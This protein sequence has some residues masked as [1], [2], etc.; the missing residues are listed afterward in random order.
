MKTY[1]PDPIDT[2]RV[3]LPASLDGLI[4]Q[5]AANTHDHWAT[6]RMADG[7]T[8]G[9]RRDDATKQHPDLVAYDELTE[10]EKEYDRVTVTETLKAITALGYKITR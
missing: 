9:E 6:K 10:S 1:E 7:W 5:L 8:Y 3:S 2:S 4:E